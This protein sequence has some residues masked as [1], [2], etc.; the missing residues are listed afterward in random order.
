[1]K[2]QEKLNSET[3]Q[4][5]KG[6]PEEELCRLSAQKGGRLVECKWGPGARASPGTC[7]RRVQTR[8]QGVGVPS[9]VGQAHGWEQSRGH[10][11]LARP[12]QQKPQ[13]QSP[14]PKAAG[15]PAKRPCWDSGSSDRRPGLGD[16]EIT[17]SGPERPPA[18]ACS[19]R[20]PRRP[21]SLCPAHGVN[22]LPVS[23]CSKLFSKRGREWFSCYQHGFWALGN[24][25]LFSR[26]RLR[27]FVRLLPLSLALPSPPPSHPPHPLTSAPPRPCCTPG[28]RE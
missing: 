14:C 24:A 15:P 23:L 13:L 6:L 3:V 20:R 28:H 25:L 4:R 18:G 5:W 11:H 10:T 9:G 22:S 8:S 2:F 27:T 1:M 16:R 17:G 21:P 19:L 12:R 7:R 26:P